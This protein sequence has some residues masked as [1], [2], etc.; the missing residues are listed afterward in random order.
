[1]EKDLALI[2]EDNS[3]LSNMFSRALSDIDYQTLVISDGQ[4]ALDWLAEKTP[5]LLLL[6]LHLPAISGKDIFNQIVDDSRFEGTYIVLCTADA[7]M[8]S[9]LAEKADFLLNKPVDI[10]QLQ[11]MAER[12]KS[13]HHFRVR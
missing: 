4:K 7:R 5:R 1:M 6:D 12:L 2:V 3:L 13:N 11:R 8:G 9:L 10:A